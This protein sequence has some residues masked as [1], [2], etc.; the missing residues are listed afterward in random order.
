MAK[1]KTAKEL[2][3]RT[4]W[5]TSRG[6]WI[7]RLEKAGVRKRRGLWYRVMLC[8]DPDH[9]ANHARNINHHRVVLPPGQWEAAARTD[10]VGESWV[11]VR[12]LGGPE[13]HTL[14]E[15]E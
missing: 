5:D 1:I 10:E 11:W 6:V 8:R 13:Q 12:F 9:A 3:G 7:T 14:F 2:P 4:S 15:D